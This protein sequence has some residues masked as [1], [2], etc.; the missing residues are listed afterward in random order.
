MVGKKV[1]FQRQSSRS[2]EVVQVK[3]HKPLFMQLLLAFYVLCNDTL[4]TR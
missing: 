1:N 3:D 2:L 4:H